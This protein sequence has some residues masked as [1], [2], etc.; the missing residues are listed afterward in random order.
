MPVTT[1]EWNAVRV[2]LLTQL[3]ADG[4]S[5][6]QIARR[7]GIGTRN[8]IIGKVRPGLAGRVTRQRA[9]RTELAPAPLPA[10]VQPEE[11]GR[12]SCRERV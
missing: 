2:E 4:L 11:I 7:I 10:V 6:S 3:W 12:A 9:V 1:V 8:A 5:A